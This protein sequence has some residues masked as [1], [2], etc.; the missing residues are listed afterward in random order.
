VI[1]EIEE[2]AIA[3]LDERADGSRTFRREQ[4]AANLEPADRS[5]KQVAELDG[6]L[7]CVDVERN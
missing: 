7:V 2:H 5:A 1:F 3:A 6:A 4:A